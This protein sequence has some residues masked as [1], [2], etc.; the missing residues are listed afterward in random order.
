MTLFFHFLNEKGFIND[1]VL[2]CA[3]SLDAVLDINPLILIFL[4]DGTV[5]LMLSLGLFTVSS[6]SNNCYMFHFNILNLFSR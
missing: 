5:P 6:P 3:S 1:C 4:G 2:L